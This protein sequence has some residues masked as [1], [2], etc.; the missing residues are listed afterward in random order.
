M[1]PF[2][3]V[4]ANTAILDACDLSELIAQAIEEDGGSQSGIATA[5]EKYHAQM[6]P[7]GRDAVLSSRSVGEE[8]GGLPV[9][10]KGRKSAI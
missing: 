6:S 8:T 1:V 9:I 2:R 4:G 7:R 3:G 10:A 5:L